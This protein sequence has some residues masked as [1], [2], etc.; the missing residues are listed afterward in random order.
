MKGYEFQAVIEARKEVREMFRK[1]KEDFEMA[2]KT[3]E[4][5]RRKNGI[6]GPLRNKISMR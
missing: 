6:L 3:G 2:V 4:E 5:E 1:N